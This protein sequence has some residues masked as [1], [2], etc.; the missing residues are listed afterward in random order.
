MDKKAWQ[1]KGRGHRA[2]LRE[3]FL[4]RGIASLSDAEVLELLLSF[5][6]PRS[7]CKGPAR[8][9]LQRLGSL[10]A[11]LEAPVAL[12]G[13]IKGIGPKNGM[14]VHFVQAVASRYLRDRL[15]KKHYL[16]AS[17]EV[18]DYLV[19][20][21]RGLKR[22]VL[23]VIYLDSA[24]A[25]LDSE[26]VAEGSI[27]VNTVY[28]RELVKQALAHNAAALIIAHNHPSGALSPSPQDLQLTKTLCLLGG[29]MQIQILD[30]IIIGAGSYS[31]ADHGIMT[32]IRRQCR[33]TMDVLQHP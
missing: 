20:A 30:H 2:R 9:A 16:H 7:D 31:F 14:A 12:L 13:E 27:N 22:E 29:L 6:T 24:H 3:R 23:T 33:E 17:Q 8:A 25:I 15:K 26:T 18:R 5:G 1:E 10:A 28:P 19:H 11:V 21:M 4:E 32:D